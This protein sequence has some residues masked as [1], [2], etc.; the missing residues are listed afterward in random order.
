MH[1]PFLTNV[2]WKLYCSK[3]LSVQFSRIDVKDVKVHLLIKKGHRS[4]KPD[5]FAQVVQPI[6]G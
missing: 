6:Q 5:R 3:F 4:N 2:S 1:V